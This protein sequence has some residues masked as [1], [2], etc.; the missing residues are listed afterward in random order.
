[1][2]WDLFQF[3]AT[4]RSSSL[5]PNTTYDVY[6]VYKIIGDVVKEFLKAQ[7]NSPFVDDVVCFIEMGPIDME[8]FVNDVC[9]NR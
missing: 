1:M 6:V 7:A 2:P 9:S 4:V 8:P 5:S 3:G